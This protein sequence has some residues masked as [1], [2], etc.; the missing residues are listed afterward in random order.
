MSSL[1]IHIPFCSEICSYCDFKR[2]KTDDYN[3]INTYIENTI[4]EIKLLNLKPNSLKT[5]Y[6]GGGTPNYLDYNNL[7]KLLKELSY[8]CKN[9][10]EFTIECNPEFI[11]QQQID[12]FKKNKINRISLGAQSLNNNILID[13]KRKHNKKSI[14]KSIKLLQKNGIYNISC[15][16]IYNYKNI[17]LTDLKDIFIFIEEYQ[18]NHISFYALELK[19][20]SLLT[21]MG[22]K[23]NYNHEEM[24]LEFIKKTM[25]KMGFSRYEISNWCRNDKFK[26]KHNLNYWHFNNWIGIG[27]GSFGLNNYNYYKNDGSILKPK[28]INFIYNKEELEK[29]KILM[30]LRL[31]E[32]FDLN[33]PEN[34]KLFEKYKNKLDNYYIDKKNHLRANNIDCLNDTILNLF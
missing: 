23:L 28:K 22:Y 15:D 30:G 24:Q 9:D 32:G 1:Y 5:I 4:S 29:M 31:L 33:V 20:N 10:T 19:E 11:T 14:I 6:L 21:K 25:K 27:Y 34:L 2:I 17:S 26:S 7:D 12:I 3:L 13:M 8:Y 16:F 18:I